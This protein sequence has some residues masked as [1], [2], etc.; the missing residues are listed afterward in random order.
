MEKKWKKFIRKYITFN[1][2]WKSEKTILIYLLFSGVNAIRIHDFKN[3]YAPLKTEKRAL[4]NK[5]V[6]CIIQILECNEKVLL[7]WS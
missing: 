5:N 7:T 3:R 1:C 6:V 4:F 2:K